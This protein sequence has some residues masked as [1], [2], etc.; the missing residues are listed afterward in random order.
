M[1]QEKEKQIWIREVGMLRWG[2]VSVAI[3]SEMVGIGLTEK[4]KLEQKLDRGAGAN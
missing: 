1:Q 4:V 3:L 2:R